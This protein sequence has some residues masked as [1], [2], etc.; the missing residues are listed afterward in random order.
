MLAVVLAVLIAVA[1]WAE[2]QDAAGYY[3]VLGATAVA[4]VLASLLQPILRR[5]EAPAE[6]RHELVLTLD[7]PPSEEAVAAAVEALEKHGS[8]VTKVV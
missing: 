8:H 6:R 7:S 3:R 1:V 2:I 5:M 4:A